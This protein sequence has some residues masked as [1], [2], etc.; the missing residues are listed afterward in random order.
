MAMLMEHAT[1]EP[2]P[3]PRRSELEIPELRRNSDLVLID[4]EGGSDSES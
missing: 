3:P 4:F 1:A 2:V